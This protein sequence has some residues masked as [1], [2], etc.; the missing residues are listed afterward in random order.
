MN[1]E[2]FP[3][4]VFEDPYLTVVVKPPQMLSED[5]DSPQSLARWLATR[6]KNGYVGVIHRLD[7][8]VGGV[9][10]YARTPEAAAS[11]SR[12]V[13]E[14]RV[15]KE[16]LAV[17]HGEPQSPRGSLSDLLFY[18][19]ARNKSFVVDRARK[20]VKE[21]RLEYRVLAAKDHPAYGKVSL[22]AITLQTGR[23]H[24]IRVQFSSRCHPLVGDG[25]YGAND[26]CP[27][28]LFSHRLT[29]EHPKTKQLLSFEKEPD[30]PIFED[31]LGAQKASE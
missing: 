10:V 30:A 24:Q 7:R 1:P 4:I 27:I 11:L 20:G 14:N 23:T 2:L 13:S 31:F 12:A 15:K 16:Y 9:M 8:G 18:D 3:E 6:N 17:V 29:L 25:K 19:R 5:S 21:A 22:V 28:A 26:H